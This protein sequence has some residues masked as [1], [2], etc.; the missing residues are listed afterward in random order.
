MPILQ[1]F[2][3]RQPS[4]KR[5][6][7]DLYY[8]TI[9]LAIEID[10]KYHDKSQEEDADRERE[11]K[12]SIDCE[13]LR[14]DAKIDTFNIG[15]AIL[16]INNRIKQKIDEFKANRI[17]QAWVELPTQTLTE[18][19]DETKKT[20]V[21][22]TS[23]KDGIPEW[24]YNE[25]SQYVQ[26]N[27]KQVIILSGGT[28]QDSPLVAYAAFKPD[29]YLKS[30]KNPNFISPT[31]ATITNCPNINKYISKW[32]FPRN[33]AYSKDLYRPKRGRRKR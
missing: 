1:S 23:F 27:A 7:I 6:F 25:I 22:R 30:P 18:F 32:D 17:F 4:N 13:F 19:L 21:M 15:D 29:V 20:I 26:G 24:P 10:E 3:P 31:G 8:P 5:A 2:V 9:K 33:I 28:S 11:I 12:N 16:T 14:I